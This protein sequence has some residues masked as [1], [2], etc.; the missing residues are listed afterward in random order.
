MI[1]TALG[2][3]RLALAEMEFLAHA[4]DKVDILMTTPAA[5]RRCAASRPSATTPARST[6]PNGRANK[7]T[8][9]PR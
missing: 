4:H 7:A 2:G 8:S 1:M 9:L 5:R 3:N 6:Q